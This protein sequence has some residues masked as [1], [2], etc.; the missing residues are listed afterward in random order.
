MI[1]DSR[2]RTPPSARTLLLPGE[3]LIFTTQAA[4]E[5]EGLLARAGA[6][7][8]ARRGRASTAICAAVLAR[9]AQLEINDVWVEAGARLNGAL[10]QAGLIDELVLYMAPKLLGDGARGMFGVP[11]LAALSDGW[12]LAIEEV[13]PIGGDLRIVARIRR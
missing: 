8:R 10:L 9:L 11:A 6:Q 4:D 3:V 2:L 5:A 12:D 13:S 1:L 7:H